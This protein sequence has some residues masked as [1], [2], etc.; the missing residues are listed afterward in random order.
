MTETPVSLLD[1]LCCGPTSAEWQRFVLLFTPLLDRWARRF[2]VPE[3]DRDD[4]LQEVFLLLFRKLPEFRYDPGGSFRA[5]LWT[6]FRHATLAWMKHQPRPVG[7]AELLDSV[8]VPDGL[9]EADATEFRHY[10]LN[11]VLAV[12]QTD[13]PESTWRMFWQVV[14]EGRSG[15]EVARTFGVT[16]NA[17]YLARARVLARLREQLAGLDR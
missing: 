6:V 1:R 8:P 3:S 10:L 2:G 4:L 17:V 5:W 13:F 9:A 11:R 7:H 16:P 14:I 12:V 15:V